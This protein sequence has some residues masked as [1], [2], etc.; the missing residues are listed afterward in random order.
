METILDYM[1][2]EKIKDAGLDVIKYIDAKELS[3]TEKAS[4]MA[5]ILASFIAAMKNMT[6]EGVEYEDVKEGYL[7]LI[8][9]LSAK[10]VEEVDGDTFGFERSLGHSYQ[11]KPH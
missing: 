4:L 9:Y 5:G 7:N 11:G 1:I 6:P 8:D 2:T 10:L 3:N